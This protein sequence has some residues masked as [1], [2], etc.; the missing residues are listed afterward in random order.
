MMAEENRDVGEVGTVVLGVVEGTNME[1]GD[2][3]LIL[4]TSS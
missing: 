3:V 2:D 4:T 1:G